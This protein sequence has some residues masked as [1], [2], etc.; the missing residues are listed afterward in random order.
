[1]LCGSSIAYGFT[2]GGYNA[3]NITIEPLAK[4]IL[5]PT[6]EGDD[7]LAKREAFL[8]PRVISEFVERY[9]NSPLPK[10]DIGVNV[11]VEFGVPRDRALSPRQRL[12]S[13][14]NNQIFPPLGRRELKP[15]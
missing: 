5:A 4:R 14:V 9:N 1:M 10:E 6:E 12:I 3:A 7:L 8:R 13:C 15:N 11:L 2:S